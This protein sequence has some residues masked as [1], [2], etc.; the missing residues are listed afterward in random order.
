MDGS[1]VPGNKSRRNGVGQMVD[2]L[3]EWILAAVEARGKG[4]GKEYNYKIHKKGRTMKNSN[5][6]ELEA[7]VK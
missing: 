5:L 3:L 2:S 1:G 7:L 4:G 6:I